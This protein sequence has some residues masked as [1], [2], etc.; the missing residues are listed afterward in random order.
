MGEKLLKFGLI[1]VILNSIVLEAGLPDW[2]V[3]MNNLNSSEIRRINKRNI[4][5]FVLKNNNST[6]PEIATALGLSMPTVGQ[7]TDE[8]ISDGLVKTAG[9]KASS[10]GR[11]AMQ[12]EPVVSARYAMGIDITKQHVNFIIVDLTGKAV[13]SER[14]RKRFEDK[15]EFYEFLVDYRRNLVRR[16]GIDPQTLLGVGVSVQ[17]IVSADQ[18]FFASHMIEGQRVIPLHNYGDD[19]P[20]HFFNDGTAS[21]MAECFADNTPDNFVYLML[22]RTVGG[23]IVHNGK[24]WEGLN[25]HAGEFGHMAIH[26]EREDMCYC[27]K[28][29]HIWCYNSVRTLEDF[30]GG[31]YHQFFE[32]LAAGEETYIRRFDTFLDDLALSILN[33]RAV[34]DTTVII[35]GYISAYLG[36]HMPYLKA[37]VAELDHLYA[38][39]KADIVLGQYAVEAAATGAARYFVEKY[40]SNL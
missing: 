30:V 23:A 5:R 39:S 16:S 14:I 4:L 25:L 6:K 28:R 34:F 8:L 24:V 12:L 27:G 15:P 17:G 22:S 20:H 29:G 37:K 31:T 40:I 26:P 21:C 9:T 1:S 33:L 13:A 10:G 11:R 36:P 7:L 3:L 35:G 18:N 19:Y 32:H 38:E 2:L